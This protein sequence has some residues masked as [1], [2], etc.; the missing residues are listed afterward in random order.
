MPFFYLMCHLS[1]S[2]L[3]KVTEFLSNLDP[4]PQNYI[5]FVGE[6]MTSSRLAWQARNTQEN[7]FSE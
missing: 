7:F 6:S 3:H 5:L 1:A 2:Y 4:D